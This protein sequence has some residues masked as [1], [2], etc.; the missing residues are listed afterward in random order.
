MNINKGIA[1]TWTTSRDN[2]NDPEYLV[3][4]HI[5]KKKS[6]VGCSKVFRFYA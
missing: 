5:K 2:G 3:R 6:L 4:E 1:L